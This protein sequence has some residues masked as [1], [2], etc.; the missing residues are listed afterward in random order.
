VRSLQAPARGHVVAVLALVEDADLEVGKHLAIERDGPRDA[1][2]APELE[3]VDVVDEVPGVELA[4]AVEVSVRAHLLE[5]FARVVRM[6]AGWRC[7]RRGM[8]AC[9]AKISMVA[10]STEVVDSMLHWRPS[11]AMLGRSR[12][13][14]VKN[15]W[16]W[17]SVKPSQTSACSSRI[18]A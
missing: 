17:G 3:R 6:R 16:T 18:Q 10:T 12:P 14:P 4:S 5:R 8:W 13:A 1:L 15:A 2:L 9:A 7:H 11:V